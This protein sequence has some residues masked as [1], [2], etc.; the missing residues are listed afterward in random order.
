ML[1]DP[2]DEDYPALL[3]FDSKGKA[4]PNLDALLNETDKRRVHAS[5]KLYHLYHTP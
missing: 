4:I 2:C 1:L 5:I 3:T